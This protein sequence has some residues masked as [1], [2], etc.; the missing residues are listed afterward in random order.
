CRDEMDARLEGAIVEK[1]DYW[2]RSLLRARRGEWPSSYRA[3]NERDELAPS[4]GS[5]PQADHC[6]LPHC[7]VKG[8]VVHHS[9][10]A[11]PTSAQG[12]GRVKTKSDL[13]IA[14]SGRQIF[15]FF[16]SP[17]DHRGQNSGCDY[18]P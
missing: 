1:S 17:H 18:T 13:V 10:L 8:G 5:S 2:Y 15:A 4:H 11:H 3:A 12:L 9:I 7:G 6:T 16:C 14:P